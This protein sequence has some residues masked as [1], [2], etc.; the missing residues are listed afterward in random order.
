MRTPLEM[1][2]ACW[3]ADSGYIKTDWYKSIRPALVEHQAAM[4]VVQMVDQWGNGL[5]H[6]TAHESKMV[7]AAR[8]ILKKLK[9]RYVVQRNWNGRW[10][11]Y[12]T[13]EQEPYQTWDDKSNADIH[14]AEMNGDDNE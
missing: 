2:D 7:K 3:A 14:C 10:I 12:D 11:V 13:K 5:R 8:A 6:H 4:E 1:F 9:K